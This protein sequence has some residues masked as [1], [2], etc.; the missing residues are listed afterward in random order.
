M[1]TVIPE[2]GRAEKDFMTSQF[3][4]FDVWSVLATAGPMCKVVSVSNDAF[5]R[6]FGRGV[7]AC[8]LAAGVHGCV[9]DQG[10]CAAAWH[11]RHRAGVPEAGL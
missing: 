8:G 9:P 4:S 3:E 5:R 2:R 1:S 11:G 10:R 7:V 6:H